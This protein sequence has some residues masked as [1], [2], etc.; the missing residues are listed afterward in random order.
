MSHLKYLLP[1]CL[2]VSVVKAADSPMLDDARKTEQALA[3]TIQRFEQAYVFIGGGSGVLISDDGLML[4]NDHVA[5]SSKKWLVRNGTK[6]YKADV[7]GTD[8]G[9]DITLLKLQDARNM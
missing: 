1:L 9:G 6:N 5:K 4:T 8:P 2:C 7:L 3:A